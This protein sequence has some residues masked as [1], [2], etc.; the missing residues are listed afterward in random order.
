MKE[1][2]TVVRR[3][4]YF[5][6]IDGNG[7]EVARYNGDGAKAKADAHADKLNGGGNDDAAASGRGGAARGGRGRGGQ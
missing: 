6:V 7:A 4:G 3:F 5:N 1:T 2:Y